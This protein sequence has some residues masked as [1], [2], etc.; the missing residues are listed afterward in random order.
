MLIFPTR[1]LLPRALVSQLPVRQHCDSS[2]NPRPLENRS[3]FIVWHPELSIGFRFSL[4]GHNRRPNYLHSHSSNW[5]QQTRVSVPI[6]IANF[7]A[8]HSVFVISIDIPIPAATSEYQKRADRRSTT[9][10][11]NSANIYSANISEWKTECV[12]VCLHSKRPIKVERNKQKHI[13]EWHSKH[14]V[15]YFELHWITTAPARCWLFLLYSCC[16]CCTCI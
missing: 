15:D 10:T 1:T 14:S 16:C 7:K 5:K 12:C 2:W 6:K 3:K 4:Y 9:T 13:L 8:H 11:D